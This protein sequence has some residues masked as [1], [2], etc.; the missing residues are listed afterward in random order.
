MTEY[1]DDQYGYYDPYEQ[2]GYYFE[3][4]PLY[5]TELQGIEHYEDEFDFEEPYYEE[6]LYYEETLVF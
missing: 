5:I 3:E 1:E 6:E 2:E 4:E